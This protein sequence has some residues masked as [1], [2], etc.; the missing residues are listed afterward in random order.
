[1]SNIA[2][3]N[4]DHRA[5]KP[6]IEGTLESKSGGALAKM[7]SYN[8]GYFAVTPAG[9]LH[10]FKD[11]DDFRHDPIPENSFY[12]PDCIIGAVDGVKFTL[13]GK[14]T[15]G[16][17]LSQKIAQSK[18]ISFKAHNQ[19]DAQQWHNIIASQTGG[20]S[21]SAP[22]SPVQSR[23]TSGQ[24]PNIDTTAGQQT[25]V[26]RASPT[27]AGPHSAAG[28]GSHLSPTANQGPGT[29][30]MVQQS[31]ATSQGGAGSHFHGPGSTGQ[32][33]EDKKFSS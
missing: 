21:N 31:V 18:E 22:V 13:K 24:Q 6:L 32:P 28:Q 33:L 15:S 25:G 5:T 2:F 27:S 29:S 19:G 11:N 8:S 12:L 26:V 23:V 17:K 3:P 4:Q 20:S 7:K 14:D 16:G 30:P 1:M 10:E 9:F